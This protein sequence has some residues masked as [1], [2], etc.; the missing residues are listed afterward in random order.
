MLACTELSLGLVCA[1]TFDWPL[2]HG[3]LQH[4]LK[5]VSCVPGRQQLPAPGCC[6]VPWWVILP[7][8]ASLLG[9]HQAKVW[10]LQKQAILVSFSTRQPV[11][12]R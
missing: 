10:H 12:H 4:M 5:N 11:N 2:R 1:L 9:N 3:C 6:S 7:A 8:C